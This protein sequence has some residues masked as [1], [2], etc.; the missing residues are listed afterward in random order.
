MRRGISRTRGFVQQGQFT[1]KIAFFQF[2]QRKRAVIQRIQLDMNLALFNDIHTDA[3][4][5]LIEN[6]FSFLV[7]PYMRNTGNGRQFLAIQRL[8]NRHALMAIDNGPGRF[9]PLFKDVTPET[10]THTSVCPIA[11]IKRCSGN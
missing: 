3:G 5:I 6:G 2:R 11:G 7:F 10:V 8:K 9:V 1:E 4:L